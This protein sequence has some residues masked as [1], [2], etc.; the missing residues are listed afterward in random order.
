MIADLPHIDRLA[1]I[2]VPLIVVE[3]ADWPV[4]RQLVEVRPAKAD[5]L[6]IGIGEQP[7]L[8]QRVIGEVDPWHDM[9]WMEGH[10]LCLGEYIVHI[11]VQ[12]HFSNPLHGNFLFRPQLRRI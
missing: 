5:E 2:S 8:Q 3:R 4:D 7:A 10:L 12:C 11:A 6:R 9:P 1:G